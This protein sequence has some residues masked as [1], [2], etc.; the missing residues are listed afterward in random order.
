MLVTDAYFF[1]EGTGKVFERAKFGDFRVL[2]DGRALLV[3]LADAD[4]KPIP[5]L[6]QAR[7]PSDEAHTADGSAEDASVVDAVDAPAEPADAA[8]S[9]P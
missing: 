6:T 4:G 8:A 5:V 7:T 3:G 1:P 2:P 9:A